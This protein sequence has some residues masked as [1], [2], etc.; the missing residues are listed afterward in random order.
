MEH[1][2]D[3][4]CGGRES[5]YAQADSSQIF[6]TMYFQNKYAFIYLVMWCASSLAH[7]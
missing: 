2:I 7:L 4:G 6:Q 5:K 1:P 3:F